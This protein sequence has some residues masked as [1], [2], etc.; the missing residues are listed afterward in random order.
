MQPKYTVL[1]WEQPEDGRG[2]LHVLVEGFP[3]WAVEV[4]VMPT[5]AGPAIVDLRIYPWIFTKDEDE[6]PGHFRQ[7]HRLFHTKDPEIAAMWS[8]QAT[9]PVSGI[10]A[11]LI[12]AINAGQLLS[13][14]QQRAAQDLD[15]NIGRAQRFAH[16]KKLDLSRQFLARAAKSQA[17]SAELPKRTGRR[18]NGIDHYLLWAVRY[19]QKTATGVAHPIAALAKETGEEANYIRDTIHE[20]RRRGLLTK[21]PGGEPGRRGG[22]RAGGELTDEALNLLENRSTED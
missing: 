13:L 1:D 11:R 22:G 8:K 3:E 16:A 21:P 17:L 18:G 4:T 9:E 14:A 7:G 15:A 20:A 2:F 12:R 5:E 6:G 10:P 19:A